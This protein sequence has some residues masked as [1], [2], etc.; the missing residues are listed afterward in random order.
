MENPLTTDPVTGPVANHQGICCHGMQRSEL[1]IQW[2]LAAQ[3]ATGRAAGRQVAPAW[4]NILDTYI[5]IVV[6]LYLYCGICGVSVYVTD[7]NIYIYIVVYLY[8]SYML[9]LDD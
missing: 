6:Y 4:H 2:E 7:H 1:I 5:Y 9:G 3:R 8:I